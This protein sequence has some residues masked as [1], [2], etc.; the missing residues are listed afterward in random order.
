[1]WSPSGA[2]SVTVTLKSEPPPVFW[3]VP[4]KLYVNCPVFPLTVEHAQALLTV[5]LHSGKLPLRKSFSTASVDCE[6]R[7][8]TRKL[9]KQPGA[10]PGKS[11]LRSNPPSK[12]P[13]TGTTFPPPNFVA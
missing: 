8:S 7:V 11:A 10:P 6:E 3:N 13:F 2:E 4:P 9:L 12:K 5:K 1:M